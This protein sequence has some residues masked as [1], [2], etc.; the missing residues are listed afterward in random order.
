M[1]KEKY[2]YF[3]KDNFYR[4]KIIKKKP[5]ISY[6]K[7]IKCDFEETIKIRNEI[8]KNNNIILNKNANW[9]KFKHEYKTTLPKTPYSYR[10]LPVPKDALNI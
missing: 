6:D 8:L 9:N 10:T 1:M 7:Y 5:I 4:V 3:I 2:I